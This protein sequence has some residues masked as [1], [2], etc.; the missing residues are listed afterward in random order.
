M[1]SGSHGGGG[2]SHFGGGSFG[3]GHFGGGSSLGSHHSYNGPRR[4]GRAP[5]HFHFFF[6]GGRRYAFADD[7]RSSIAGLL[8]GCL[9]CFLFLIFWAVSIPGSISKM[10][11]IKADYTYYQDMIAYAEEHTELLI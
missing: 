11:K 1:P 5:V 3:G 9:I 2:G 7:D 4:P 10:N 6:W 8:F